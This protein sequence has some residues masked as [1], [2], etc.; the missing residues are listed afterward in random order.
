[1]ALEQILRRARR[2]AGP[3]SLSDTVHDVGTGKCST[4]G[5]TFLSAQQFYEHLDD[6]VLS[7]I[8]DQ[9]HNA[10]GTTESTGHES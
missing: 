6:C 4:C 2:Q 9:P 7:V 5:I 8:E 10:Q 3:G 1:M